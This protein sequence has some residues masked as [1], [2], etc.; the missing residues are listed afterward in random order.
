MF[1]LRFSSYSD[2]KIVAAVNVNLSCIYLVVVLMSFNLLLGDIL[3]LGHLMQCQDWK[4]SV[5]MYCATSE[6]TGGNVDSSRIS[7]QMFM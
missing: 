2:Q 7:R 6:V 4:R 1:S 5:I 3:D